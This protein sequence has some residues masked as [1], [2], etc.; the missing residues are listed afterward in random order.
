MLLGARGLLRAPFAAGTSLRAVS[1]HEPP[2]ERTWYAAAR[3]GDFDHDGITDLAVVDR[4][5]PGVQILAGGK[6]G[7]QR[8]LAI[9]VFE[10]PPSG[11]PD[12]EQI[13]RAHV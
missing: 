1:V 7:L 9:P 13:G 12:T 8:A 3:S 6:D 11:E 5:L 10:A 2:I 4:H